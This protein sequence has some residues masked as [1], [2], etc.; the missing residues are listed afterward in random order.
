VLFEKQDNIREEVSIEP[1]WNLNLINFISTLGG[2]APVSIEPS[3]NLN[4][5]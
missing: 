4:Q 2:A 3:W 5:L 1:S